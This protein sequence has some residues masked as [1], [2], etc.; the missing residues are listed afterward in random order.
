M[1]VGM[2]R[3][4]WVCRDTFSKR[5]SEPKEYCKELTVYYRELPMTAKLKES[6][7]LQLDL[8]YLAG[9]PYLDHLPWF[10]PGLLGRTIAA[11]HQAT[12]NGSRCWCHWD[13][14]PQNI[15]VDWDY[16]C[17][18]LVDF[19]ETEYDFPEADLTH[20]MLFWIQHFNDADLVLYKEL[21]LK[22][23]TLLMPIDTER[24][25]QC[26]PI[27]IARF[28]Q[29]RIDYGKAPMLLLNNEGYIKRLLGL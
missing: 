23:Y 9:R 7:E 15:L 5:F 10:F 11:F 12:F 25:N 29:R 17:Y 4:T 19:A 21:F 26:L 18:Y 27:S 16:T 13:N 24:W 2:T 22:A 6:K 28:N 14:N 8:E 20:L 3:D 1:R